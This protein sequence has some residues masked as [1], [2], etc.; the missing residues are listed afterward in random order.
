MI[1]TSGGEPFAFKGVDLYRFEGHLISEIRQYWKF[2]RECLALLAAERSG[3]GGGGV[4]VIIRGLEK[5]LTSH[6]FALIILCADPKNKR[7]NGLQGFQG[8]PISSYGLPD[9]TIEREKDVAIL[10]LQQGPVNSMGLG[11]MR[12]ALLALDVIEADSTVRGL[13]IRSGLKKHVFTAGLD[14]KELHAPSTS[15]KQ[16]EEYWNTLTQFLTR[17]FTTPLATA[18]AIKGQCPA[19]GCALGLTCDYRAAT[20]DT[21]I[22]L[23]EIALGIVVPPYWCELMAH[24]VGGHEAERLL[25]RA[26]MLNAGDA[27]AKGM[28]DELVSP[29]NASN[30]AFDSATRAAINH[31]QGTLLKM[32]D[33]GRQALKHRLRSEFG[34]RWRSL[35]REEAVVVWTDLC[36]ESCVNKLGV[37]LAS[38]SK[39]KKKPAKL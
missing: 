25:L 7:P 29:K 3:G 33:T 26:T 32:P 35:W 31:L 17:V 22:G 18:A 9:V 20:E 11:L 34:Q 30:E 4:F 21:K 5:P 10:S 1:G 27:L 14:I 16:F 19:G 13:V 2:D 23:N 24:V 37:V 6:Y 38:L 8:Y 36:S 28:L 15:A 39:P 12:Q